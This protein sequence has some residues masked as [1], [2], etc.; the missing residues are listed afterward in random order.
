M[1]ALW[2]RATLLRK[3]EYGIVLPQV[4]ELQGLNVMLTE[5]RKEW[6]LGCKAEGLRIFLITKSSCKM[7]IEIVKTL[8]LR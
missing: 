5:K 2:I 6:P 8:A 1:F 7:L 3:P 4:H